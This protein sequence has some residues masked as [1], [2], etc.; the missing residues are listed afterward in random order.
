MRSFIS[1]LVIACSVGGCA[2]NINIRNADAHAQSGYNAQR[3]GDW[4]VARRQFAQAVVNADLGKAEAGGKA[5]VNYEY[6]RSLGVTCFWDE[7]EKYLLRSKQFEEDRNHSPYLPLYEL[8]LLTEKQGKS[9]QAA[10]Y[11]SQLIPLMEKEGLRAKYP[12]GVADAYERYAFAL[13]ATGKFAEAAKNRAEAHTLRAAN[14]EA[15]P[16]GQ[17][18][19]YGSACYKNAS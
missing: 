11:F 7:S 16:F 18:T 5:M 2:S 1:L 4:E 6:G 12:L 8:G 13:E 3:N 9:N 14:S 19:P 10:S 17:V 15:K